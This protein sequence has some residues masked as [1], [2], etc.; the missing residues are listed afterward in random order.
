[1]K[2]IVLCPNPYKDKDLAVTRELMAMLERA[3]HAVRVCPE[4]VDGPEGSLPPGLEYA[5]LYAALD[6]AALVVSLGGDGTIMHTARRMVGY[7]V[8]IIGV[9]LGTVGFLA[10]LERGELP[11]LLDAAR[12]DFTVSP[13]MMLRV[14]LERGGETSLPS[15]GA[16]GGPVFLRARSAGGVLGGLVIVC[17]DFAINDDYGVRDVEM[18]VALGV[19]LEMVTQDFGDFLVLGGVILP[20]VVGVMIIDFVDAVGL[21]EVV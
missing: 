20:I 11:R 5:D 9:N 18:A 8:P 19:V 2:H 6:G 12:G 15:H 21:R 10:E 7:S 17:D 1:M 4:L 13:R 14:E 3:G 16:I